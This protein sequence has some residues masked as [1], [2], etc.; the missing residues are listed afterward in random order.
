MAE[1]PKIV[2]GRLMAGEAGPHPDANLLTA[3]AEQGL[4]RH[5]RDNVL[6]HLAKCDE[7]REV[8]MLAAPPAEA[9]V[10]ERAS[11]SRWMGWP[12]LRWGAL[13]AC[14]VI[15]V[16][17]VS[18]RDRSNHPATMIVR[19]ESPQVAL[20]QGEAAKEKKIT[21]AA[22]LEKDRDA[23]HS[24][25]HAD[26]VKPQE[27]ELVALQPS[28]DKAPGARMKPAA[29]APAQMK[30]DMLARSSGSL[31]PARSEPTAPVSG[32][33]APAAAAPAPALDLAE[34]ASDTKIMQ[35]EAAQANLGK[36]KAAQ[37][38]NS[39]ALAK[40]AMA[41]REAM[42]SSPS[43]LNQYPYKKL[44]PRWTLSADGTL[45]RSLDAGKTWKTIPVSADATFTAVAAMDSDIWVGGTHGALYH[46]VDAGEHW[47]Q[48]VPADNGQPL[49]SNIIGIEFTD[50]LHG[51]I[52]TAS[53]ES[54]TTSDG[55]QSWRAS[56]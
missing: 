14:G 50:S 51:K 17:A 4:S 55:G 2:R 29:N 52:S 24:P 6:T 7:C 8:V 22:G 46:S 35:A 12:A 48:V 40:S 19:D 16:A 45:Q 41:K 20:K 10:P 42:A 43:A 47:T 26:V 56:R 39:N 33:A 37:D 9:T 49:T 21:I 15:V 32:I 11:T 18:L 3:F 34:A 53:Q 13:A 38:L 31:A 30:A 23:L 25:S 5:E 27:K 36:A 54:W 44:T 28:V 1:I